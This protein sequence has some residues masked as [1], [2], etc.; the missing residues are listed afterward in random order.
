MSYLQKSLL[1]IIS[2]LCVGCA[3]GPRD[4]TEANKALVR[5]YI[6]EVDAA[7]GSL[8]FVDTW[9]AADFQVY[10]NSTTPMDRA[11]F[12]EVVAGILS[13]FSDMRHEIHYMIAEEDRVAI[14]MTLH[15]THT[16]D[17]QGMPAT[18]RRTSIEEI[19]VYQIRDGTIANEWAV[20]DF[21]SLQQQLTAQSGPG[22]P[23]TGR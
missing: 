14:G 20:V 2:G 12:R 18:G 19:V 9:L 3:A 4:T 23:V 5:Q 6:Q 17:F 15:M 1:A 21:A 16:G 8:A 13:A 11:G 10:L 7:R 22:Q